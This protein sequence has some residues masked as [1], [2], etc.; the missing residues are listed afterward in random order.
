MI[1]FGNLLIGIAGVLRIVFY[2]FY[3]ILIARCI[4]SFVSP[5]PRNPIVQFIT[6]TT[7][8]VLAQVRRRIPNWGMLDLSPL[9]VIA[10][11]YFLDVVLIDSLMEYGMQFKSSVNFVPQV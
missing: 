7:E 5:D 4:L 2:F 8:P 9:L 11:I 3:W 10:L 6:G 1:V